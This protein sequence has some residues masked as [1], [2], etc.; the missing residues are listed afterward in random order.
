MQGCLLA[1]EVLFLESSHSF[2]DHFCASFLFLFCADFGAMT[3]Y[4]KRVTY[5]LLDISVSLGG[6]FEEHSELASQ[7]AEIIQN[8]LRR[9]CLD[10][11]PE[12]SL[13]HSTHPVSQLWHACIKDTSKALTHINPTIS[14]DYHYTTPKQYKDETLK[15]TSKKLVVSFVLLFSYFQAQSQRS[16]PPQ[17]FEHQETSPTPWVSICAIG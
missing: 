7:R 9:S 5:R 14:W 2:W 15:A 10:K 16:F 11:T 17:A 3:E 12:A 8:W 13:E 4:V 6:I 1:P